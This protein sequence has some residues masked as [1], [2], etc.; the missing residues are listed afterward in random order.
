MVSKKVSDNILKLRELTNKI[1]D[2]HE[3]D[4]FDIVNE[5][6]E[7]VSTTKKVM[8]FENNKDKKIRYYEEFVSKVD[9]IVN[10]NN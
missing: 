5:I 7:L 8:G 9:T 6:K 4:Y 3:I 2:S 1:C 10:Q